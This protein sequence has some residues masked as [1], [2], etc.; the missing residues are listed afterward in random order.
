MSGNVDEN[1]EKNTE[2]E[3]YTV[4]MLTALTKLTDLE[5]GGAN[6]NESQLTLCWQISESLTWMNTYTN[7]L[8]RLVTQLQNL[9]KFKSLNLDNTCDMWELV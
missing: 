1:W 2:W 8:R 4:V 3:K 5:T 9:P 6:L 7:N